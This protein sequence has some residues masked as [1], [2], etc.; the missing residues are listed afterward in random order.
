MPKFRLSF[1]ICVI[2]LALLAACSSGDESPSQA[3]NIQQIAAAYDA[4][5]AL[6]SVQIEGEIV[7]DQE[8][9]GNG[10]AD[11][12]SINQQ[13]TGVMA[14]AD[15]NATAMSATIMQNVDFGVP[16]ARGEMSMEMISAE[17]ALYLRVYDTTGVVYGPSKPRGWQNVSDD[18]PRAVFGAFA[19]DQL[20]KLISDPVRYALAENA[21]Q[22]ISQSEDQTDGQLTR[23]F[24][25]R[26]SQYALREMGIDEILGAMDFSTLGIG[27]DMG[28][29]SR[30]TADNVQADLCVWIGED[31]LIQRVESI[32]HATIKFDGWAGGYVGEIDQTL[33]ATF[34]YSDSNEPVVIAPPVTQ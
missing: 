16:D 2:L 20:V 28:R 22:R 30:Q 5:R 31:G 26:F 21:V 7:V 9:K 32:V 6:N 1:I 24:N 11:A 34:T 14:F 27:I 15:D 8:I 19:S 10:Q 18:N 25:I 12:Q 23:V 29:N 4:T 3:A 33:T 17:D 13:V